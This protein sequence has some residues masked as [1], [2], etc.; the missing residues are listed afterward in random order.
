MRSLTLDLGLRRTCR[1]VFI[2]AE[3][4]GPIL[5][6]DFLHHFG[7]LVD[8][9]RYKLVDSTTNFSISGSVANVSPVSPSLSSVGASAPYHEILARFPNISKPCFLERSVKHGITHHIETKGAPTVA[10][11]RRLA[12]DR[13]KIAKQEFEHMLQLGI[14][15]PSS[16]PW[17]SPLHMVPKKTPGDWRPCGDY[18][19]LNSITVHDNY[20]IPHLHDFSGSLHS[21]KVFSKIDLVRAYHQIP[22]DPADIGKTAVTTPFGL[23]EFVRMPFGLRNA[24]QTFQRFIDQ[25]TRGLPNCFVYIDD[26]LVASDT[27]EEHIKDLSALFQR[28]N[29]FG[30]LI[31]PAKCQLGVSSLDFLGHHITSQGIRPLAEKVEAIRQFPQPSTSGVT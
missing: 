27:A 23:F 22:V 29:D 4:T 14:I 13:L 5:G 25:V 11:P 8:L 7:L 21:K 18:R 26:V 6:V 30:V 3:V 15:R 12:P 2:I 17:A 19:A 24:A 16:S 20:P 28:F 31:N 1:W 9:R 10:R